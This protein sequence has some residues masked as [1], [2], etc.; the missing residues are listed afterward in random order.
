MAVVRKYPDRIAVTDGDNEM[1][2]RELDATSDVIAGAL[3]SSGVAA[4]S[5]VGLY[6]ARGSGTVAGLLGILKCGAAYVPIDPDYP[7]E[8]ARWTV[9][10]SASAVVVTTSD[11]A[12]AF[13]GLDVRTV[14]LDLLPASGATRPDAVRPS[15]AGPA[16]VIYTSGST[17]EPKGVLVGH[18][19]VT[20]LFSV[21]QGW[22]GFG[23]D[24][25]WTLFHSASF[26]FSVWEI[27]GALLH[28]GRLVV[29]PRDT[30]RAPAAFHELLHSERVTVLNQTPAA[31]RRLAA[32]DV[33]SPFPL[34]CL[35]TVV[36][37][38]ER[39]DPAT[40][41]DWVDRHGDDRP[42]LVNMYGI[43]EATVHASYRRLLRADLD[44]GGPSPIGVPLPDLTFQVRDPDGEPVPDG[45]PG[46]LYIEGPGVAEGY[47]DR[48]EL[49][50]ERFSLR[51]LPGDPTNPHQ[52]LRTGDRVVRLD[53]GQ[54]GY[55]GRTDD[56]IK[57]RGFRVEPG[58]VEA[59][60]G[61]HPLV[62]SVVVL[63]RD[64]GEDDVRLIAYVVPAEA[65]VNGASEKLA[66]QLRDLARSL[67]VHLRPSA[68]E[69]LETLPL[70]PQG[71]ADRVALRALDQ[72]GHRPEPGAPR[73]GTGSTDAGAAD[74]RTT[75]ARVT[76]IW[77]SV[78]DVGAEE[79]G[80]DTEFFDLGGTSLTLLRMFEQ[81]NTAFGTDL[82]I[83]VLIEGATV[84][85]LASHVDAAAP[86][87]PLPRTEE[88]G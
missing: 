15:G 42:M 48:P 1:T 86:G 14:R 74:S 52:T 71:K 72:E 47:L 51:T 9:G 7:A 6:V 33:R 37:G 23:P 36:L 40:L 60:L 77:R 43:T 4:G 39:L 63:P 13:T 79:V 44:A 75:R 65:S 41:R 61:R 3:Q 16:Y 28:G 82:D 22:F 12:S 49:T 83:T 81:V 24:D 57:I 17:G 80:P 21:T 64:Y 55:L 58:E 30:A 66:A 31:F 32:V 62:A 76:A 2:Y 35:R 88:F 10:D 50:E 87:S 19:E 18:Q 67:P 78:L 20:R 29:V 26:D 45:Q 59:L 46:E 8:R 27:W 11:L 73:P 34:D 53:D 70:T 84:R 25:V 54:Y 56:Q 38:G 68:Y 5:R 69:Q 85:G